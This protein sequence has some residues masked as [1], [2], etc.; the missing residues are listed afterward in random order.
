MRRGLIG[1]IISAAL[2]LAAPAVAQSISAQLTDPLAEV[3]ISFTSTSPQPIVA[4]ASGKTTKLWRIELT[5]ASA[6][7]ISIGDG[8]TTFIGPQPCGAI[9]LDV[10]A[11]PWMTSASGNGLVITSSAAVLVGGKASVTQQ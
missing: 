3:D 11:Y 8:V 7:N 10:S 1:I 5:C 4:G 2:A 9:T 6:T